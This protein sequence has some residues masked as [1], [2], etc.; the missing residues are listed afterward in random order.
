MVTGENWT[1]ERFGEG[2]GRQ[3]FGR[4]E[5]MRSPAALECR[6]KSSHFIGT[7]HLPGV[8]TIPG[9]HDHGA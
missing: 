3:C 6:D 4:L 2:W 8:D 9:H 7:S 1:K 5:N